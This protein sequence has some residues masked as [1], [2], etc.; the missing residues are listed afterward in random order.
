[1]GS[2]KLVNTCSSGSKAVQWIISNIGNLDINKVLI[3]SG[4]YIS[5]DSSSCFTKLSA[6]M[7][8]NDN[9]GEIQTT[10]A[11]PMAKKYNIPL[12]Y[13]MS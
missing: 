5:C 1:M 13:H 6:S 12:T 4:C 9:T 2:F 11:H 10:T 3:G 8:N 7:M